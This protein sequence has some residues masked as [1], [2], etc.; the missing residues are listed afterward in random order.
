[1][2]KENPKAVLKIVKLLKCNAN[3]DCCTCSEV[4]TCLSS[5]VTVDCS[6][7]DT[8]TG[9]S[10][11][12]SDEAFNDSFFLLVAFLRLPFVALGLVSVSLFKKMGKLQ[13]DKGLILVFCRE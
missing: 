4:P 8:S 12:L 5:S 6:G 7:S 10:A 3:Y 2:D 1:M 9:L 11:S 13:Q